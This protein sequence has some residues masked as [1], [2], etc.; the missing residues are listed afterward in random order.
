MLYYVDQTEKLFYEVT[1]QEPSNMLLHGDLHH[2]NILY[3]GRLS[4]LTGEQGNWVVIDP[5]GVTGIRSLEAGRYIL[6]AMDFTSDGTN[7]R[8]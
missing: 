3:S 1:A 8:H 6:N 4:P 7:H 5:K 2:E